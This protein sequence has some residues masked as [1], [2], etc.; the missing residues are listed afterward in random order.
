MIVA[1]ARLLR[2]GRRLSSNRRGGAVS[3][4]ALVVPIWL[5][6]A[7]GLFNAGRLYMAR[8]GIQNALGET[9]RQAT[10]WPRRDNATLTAT[11]NR[12]RFG[13]FASEPCTLSFATGTSNGQTFID[14][15]VSYTPSFW[16]LFV[17][18]SP[19]TMSFSRRAYRPDG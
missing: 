19:V 14:L 15:N 16:L 9:A 8:A 5:T 4:F 2:T 10:L 6:V 17:R 18:V 11:F 7:F 13:T 3:D 12:T 1:L